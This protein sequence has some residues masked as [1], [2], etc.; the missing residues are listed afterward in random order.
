M[1][2]MFRTQSIQPFAAMRSVSEMLNIGMNRMTAEK[3]MSLLLDGIRLDH[4]AEL[5]ALY[6]RMEDMGLEPR[7]DLINGVLEHR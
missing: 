7:Y 3:L 1:G 6:E 5:M 4:D 2:S